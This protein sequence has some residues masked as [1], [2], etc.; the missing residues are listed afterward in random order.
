[1]Q[2]K[3]D[4][5]GNDGNHELLMQQKLTP[6]L[7]LVGDIDEHTQRRLEAAVS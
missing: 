6:G 2:G 3:R 1:M 5:G 7:I 4:K